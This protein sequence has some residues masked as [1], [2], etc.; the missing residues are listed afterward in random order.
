[1]LRAASKGLSDYVPMED[2]EA[3]TVY[4]DLAKLRL[5]LA[6]QGVEFVALDPGEV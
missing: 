3:G 5:Q 4:P 1:M 2:I 6:E